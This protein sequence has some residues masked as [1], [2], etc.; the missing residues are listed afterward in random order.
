MKTW[1]KPQVEINVFAANEHVSQ[2]PYSLVDSGTY[3]AADF[4]AGGKNDYY[5]HVAGYGPNDGNG[6]FDNEDCE[7]WNGGNK[8][9]GAHNINNMCGH[10]YTGKAL[11]IRNNPTGTNNY[12]LYTDTNAFTNI[13]TFDIYITRFGKV[14]ISP[15]GDHSQEGQ[16]VRNIS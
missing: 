3:Y 4:L 6:R 13:G 16:L 8:I 11:Y 1:T 9:S 5:P 7:S 14:Q 12:T 15:E 2:C 10:W